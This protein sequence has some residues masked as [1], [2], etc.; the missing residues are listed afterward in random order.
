MGVIQGEHEVRQ[1]QLLLREPIVRLHA[2]CGQRFGITRDGWHDTER[3]E[4]LSRGQRRQGQLAGEQSIR[5]QMF[6]GG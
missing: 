2:Q 1:A 5:E 4:Q 6:A 3:V